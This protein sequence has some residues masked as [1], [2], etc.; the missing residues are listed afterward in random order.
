MSSLNKCF[1][2]VFGNLLCSQ[3]FRGAV[4]DDRFVTLVLV[5]KIGGSHG[6]S[7][8]EWIW[9]DLF[10]WLNYELGEKRCVHWYK[11]QPNPKV[12]TGNPQNLIS[13]VSEHSYQV[14]SSCSVLHNRI[15][16][17]NIVC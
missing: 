17:K 14:L 16:Q 10:Y 12:Y 2:K 3:H 8:A 6:N 11:K 15:N 1:C 13:L 7:P 4:G 9:S 5:K